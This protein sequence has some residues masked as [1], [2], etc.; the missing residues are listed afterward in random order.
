MTV[1]TPTEDQVASIIDGLPVA[2]R[3]LAEL[4]PHLQQ[5]DINVDDVAALLRRDAGLT[6][7]LIAA[8]NSAVYSSAEP[9]QSLEESLARIGYREAYRIVGAVAAQQLNDPP[10]RLY[11]I[12]PQRIRENALFTALVMEELADSARLEGRA[13]Y[14]IGLLRSIGKVV[15]DRVAALR[16]EAPSL[17]AGTDDLAAWERSA[18]GCTNT[19]LAAQVLQR[20]RF[21]ES[22]SDAIR[23]H[24]APDESAP[25]ASHL[26]N[27]AAGAA[28]LR[29]YGF[30][31]E[32]GYWQFTPTNFAV[33]NVDEGKLV[34][35]GERAFRTLTRLSAVLA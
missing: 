4:A 33:T 22:T 10:L 13:A 15:L 7:R 9:A 27:L 2:P 19:D 8:A 18:L 21:P 12:G 6:A 32:A 25:T 29:G 11:G 35:A 1:P 30:P 23:Q 31:G 20:W 3:I 28:D 5:T 24:Y 14:T 16:G 34:W 17:P 26:L